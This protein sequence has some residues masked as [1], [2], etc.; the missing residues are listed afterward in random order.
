MT[1]LQIFIR[2]NPFGQIASLTQSSEDL[3]KRLLRN[4]ELQSLIIY[5]SQYTLKQFSPAMLS[6]IP[7]IFCYGQMPKAQAIALE[8]L[9]QY[10]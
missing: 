2:G 7:Y 6:G 1:L 9:F 4:G 5:G 10:F 3:V 8:L